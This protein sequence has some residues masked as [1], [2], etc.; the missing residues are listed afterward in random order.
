[1]E[2]SNLVVSP[3]GKTWD[4]VTRNTSYIDT[5]ACVHGITRD[6]GVT[7]N[8]GIVIFDEHRGF[9]PSERKVDMCFKDF[10]FAYDRFIC[11]VDG[12]YEFFY[13]GYTGSTTKDHVITIN[14]IDNGDNIIS[15]AYTEVNATSV[16]M[17]AKQYIKRGD[18]VRLWGGWFGNN[19]D[20]H[21]GFF[22]TRVGS[23]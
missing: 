7:T 9:S 15:R 11:L 22:I 6:A 14:G 21:A 1:M 4:E 23:K 8:K 20:N 5:N 12:T 10:A 17:R 3:D 2:Q 18:H 19:D 16:S 13:S